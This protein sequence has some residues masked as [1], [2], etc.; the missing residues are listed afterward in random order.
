MGGQAAIEIRERPNAWRLVIPT[1]LIAVGCAALAVDM[2][3][4]RW[5]DARSLPGFFKKSFDLAEVFGHG[6]GV[7]A[8]LLTIWI[9][10]PQLRSRLPR[11]ICCAYLSGLAADVLKLFLAR[12]RPNTIDFSAMHSVW[13]TFGTWLPFFSSSGQQSFISAHTATA[14]GLALGLFWLLPRGKWLFGFF[15]L[16]VALQRI[17]GPYHFASDTFW[18]AAIGW[19]VASAFL[20][21][22]WL[23]S[24]FDQVE[25]KLALRGTDGSL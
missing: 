18:G 22:G 2:P 12:S 8:I 13:K 16:L 4:A 21:G 11:V 6:Q 15:A 23:A 20:P 1:V 19:L 14:I 10:S 5:F 24:R 9:L 25:S 17:A 3:L 7:A